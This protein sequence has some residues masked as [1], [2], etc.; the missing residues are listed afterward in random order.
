MTFNKRYQRSLNKLNRDQALSS[1]DVTPNEVKRHLLLLD[2]TKAAGA[3]GIPTIVLRRCADELAYSL[4]LLYQK[5]LEMGELP[6]EW[7]F[8]KITAIFKKGGKRKPENYRPVSL[9][10]QSCKVLERIIREQITD[11]V[12][13]NNLMSPHQHGFRK[14]RSCQTNLL[15]SFEVWT[16]VVDEGAPVDIVYCDFRKA[17]DTV[18]HQ[19]LIK[20]LSSYG[21]KGQV[22]AW[23]SDFLSERWQAVAVGNSISSPVKVTS[24]VPQGSVLGPLLFLL[25]VNELP[26]LTKSELKMFADDVKLFRGIESAADVQTLQ[27]DLNVLSHWSKEWLLRFNT[28]KCKVMHVGHGNPSHDY[29]MEQ[30][31]GTIERL[32]VSKLERDLGVHV[33]DTLKAT[34][35]CQIA[36]KK[37]SAALRRLK[38]AFPTLKVSSF[39][40]LFTTYVRPHIEYCMQAVGPFLRKGCKGTRVCPA[41]RYKACTRD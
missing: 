21:I 33:A 4:C 10:S 17:F 35:H 1:I 37:A 15:E 7:K 8:A 31:D 11:H 39:R 23:L 30:Q 28:S 13:T 18:S 26:K 32:Q 22:L 41:S 40:P 3:D 6:K 34:T 38:M 27:D 12:D 2:E 5:S 20:K 14:K 36:A 19:H 25:Y 24:G 29:S 9:T 16:K